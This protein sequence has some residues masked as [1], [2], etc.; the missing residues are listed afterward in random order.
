LVGRSILD[1]VHPDYRDL[2]SRRVRHM[3]E[4]EEQV[5]LIEE[6]YVRLDGQI[7][8][9]EVAAAS[10]I[11]DG[12]Q[13]VQ[14]VVRDVTQR[15][16]AEAVLQNAK[17]AAESANRAKSQF[18]A[19]MSHELR[20]PLNA[21]IG[22]SGLLRDEAEDSDQAKF[23]PDL[24]KINTAASHLLH[25][26]NDILD[27]AKIEAGQ[28]EL[29]L[30]TFDLGTLIDNTVTAVKPLVEKNGNTFEVNCASN[31]GTMR[32]DPVKLRQA[33]HKLLSNAA[34]FTEQGKITLIVERETGDVRGAQESGSRGEAT[35]PAQITFCV[36][37][38]GIGMTPEQME[39]LFQAFTQADISTTRKYSGAGLGLVICQ[40]YCQ[41]M[42]GEITVRSQVN[43]GS[44]FII[45]LP[46]EV[47]PGRDEPIRVEWIAADD[48]DTGC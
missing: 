24:Q 21:I 38:T 18:L 9:V 10:I 28:M 44:T 35:S 4:R 31:L 33:L 26:I 22:Y 36:S 42:G 6:K 8:D 12:K 47:N 46:A 16:Q 23:I 19:N 40:R 34:K 5:S 41:M 20:T 30:E 15:K 45:H 11:Y 27:L 48:E 1:I 2:V 37:D 3:Q 39:H 17:E 7:I 29:Y 13:A 32:A 43:Q 14:T 25:I